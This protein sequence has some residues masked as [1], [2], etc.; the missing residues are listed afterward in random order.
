MLKRTKG[1]TLVEMMLVIAIMG[2]LASVG[3]RMMIQL[4]NFFLLTTARGEIQRDARASIDTINRF[5]RQGKYRTIHIERKTNMA[6]YSWI[7]FKHFDDRFIQFY[8]DW[9]PQRSK[10]VLY[11]DIDGNV[12]IL[13]DKI[14]YIAFTF[15]QS[16]NP[17]LVSVSLTMGKAIY[18]GK[19][20]Q[21][22]LTIQKI[23]VMNE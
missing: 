13:S 5:L 12:S 1:Y 7:R 17:E 22:E 3:P 16:D 15:P 11:M 8:Q 4:Q 6:P 10:I 20:K 21:L 2:I 14:V 18:K 19:E 9:D 23:R